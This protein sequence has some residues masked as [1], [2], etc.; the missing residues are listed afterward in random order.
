MTDELKPCPFCGEDAAIVQHFIKGVANHLN[1]FGRCSA[2]TIR[3]R[4]RKTKEGAMAD[5][6]CRPIESALEAQVK[7]LELFKMNSDEAVN[8]FNAGFEA[9][10]K[11]MGEFD[12]PAYE[13][14]HDEWRIGWA[15]AKHHDKKLSDMHSRLKECVGEIEQ[16]WINGKVAEKDI[17]GNYDDIYQLSAGNCFAILRKYFPEELKE[18]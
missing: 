3:T 2:C 11:G 18:E 6:N 4:D 7:Y 13:Q 9:Y 5:W 14:D 8:Q 15:W 16:Q 10:G 17:S 12:Y 1:Y